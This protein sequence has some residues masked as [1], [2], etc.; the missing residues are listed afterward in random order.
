MNAD[1]VVAGLPDWSVTIGG[2]TWIAK[3]LSWPAYQRA[4]QAAATMEDGAEGAPALFEA[5]LRAALR[6]AFPP[7]WWYVLRPSADPVDAI[8][9]LPAA[10]RLAVVQDFFQFLAVLGQPPRNAMSGPNAPSNF[11][12]A[13]TP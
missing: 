7:R 1:D 8:L 5:A 4:M 13:A 12:V 10:A 11:S 6:A 2:R 9:R 3:P